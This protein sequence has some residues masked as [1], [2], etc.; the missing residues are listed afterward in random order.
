MF[1][2]TSVTAK[3]LLAVFLLAVGSGAPLACDNA[4]VAAAEHSKA[5]PAA[6]VEVAPVRTG[7][8]R[9]QWRYLGEVRAHLRAELAVGAEGAVESVSVREGDRVERG[10]LLV[11]IDTSLATARLRSLR[12]SRR[13]G[14]TQLKQAARDAKRATSLGSQIVPQAEI[15]RERTTEKVLQAEVRG[16]SAQARQAQAELQRHRVEAPFD[17]VV[18]ARTVDPGDWVSS[19]QRVLDL[20]STEKAEVLVGVAPALLAYIQEGDPAT[21]EGP[22]GAKVEADIVGIVRALDSKTRTARVRLIPRELPPWL[23][24][25]AAVDVVFGVQ[26]EGEG[27]LVPRDALV[28]GVTQTRVFRVVSGAAK[29]V[30]V[31]VL[32]TSGSEALVRGEGLAPG[33]PVVVRGNERLRPGQALKI[34]DSD[35]DSHRPQEKPIDE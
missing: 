24:P 10:M 3:R 33:D 27:L 5:P 1:R 30:V 31:E 20:V 9:D 13:R 28:S 12:A 2:P 14:S 26:R 16:L 6:L 21:L 32:A 7:S 34:A 29:P 15:E 19:G 22:G 18:A 11:A 17:G 4:D 35:R 23:L 8:F 25:G